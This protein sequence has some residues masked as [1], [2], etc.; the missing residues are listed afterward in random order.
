MSNRGQ[1]LV[2]VCHRSESISLA[3]RSCF[4]AQLCQRVRR[5]GTAKW[6]GG[7]GTEQPPL[8]ASCDKAP[9]FAIYTASDTR[10]LYRYRWRQY[11][12]G[13]GEHCETWPLDRGL[14]AQCPG[15]VGDGSSNGPE[16][17]FRQLDDV[18]PAE[19]AQMLATGAPLAW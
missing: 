15:S 13:L 5:A 16:L 8:A 10:S 12:K 9:D 7:P 3:A 18:S 19:T 1:G 11:S 6:S 14:R 4:D 17:A 2:S